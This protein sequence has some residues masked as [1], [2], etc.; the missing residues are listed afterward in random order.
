[1]FLYVVLL[2][3]MLY[4][5]LCLV[6]LFKLSYHVKLLYSSLFGT[7]KIIRRLLQLKLSYMKFV[8]LIKITD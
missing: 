8:T 2:N 6:K 4:A 7:S 5:M 1:M 3:V